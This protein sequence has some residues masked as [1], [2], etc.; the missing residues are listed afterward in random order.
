MAGS[1]T[2]RYVALWVVICGCGGG[3]TL[4]TIPAPVADAAG[5]AMGSAVADA[6]SEQPTLPEAS[7]GAGPFSA[8]TLVA[9][10]SSPGSLDEDPTFTEDLLE[11]YF[12]S[13]RGGN[14]D[15]WRS[16]RLAS[17]DPWGAPMRVAELSS[18]QPDETPSVSLDGLSI[19]I[20][21][22][23][24][25]SKKGNNIW[26]STRLSRASAWGPPTEVTELSSDANDL[27]PA[28][29]EDD[30]LM[31]FASDRPGSA[32]QDMYFSARPD[33]SSPW[34]PPVLIPRVNSNA[35]DWDAFLGDHALQIFFNSDRGG[36]GGDLYFASRTSSSATF[37]AVSPLS[38]LN[39][40][41]NDSDPMLSRD[42]RYIMFGSNRSGNPEIY[43]ARR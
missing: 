8:P 7:L 16:E 35:N 1:A 22:A 40:P 15:I 21:S 19:W 34:S 12:T 4:G 42:L 39:S 33:K 28:T 9:E 5:E 37:G 31:A 11:L 24:P 25:G 6:S 2:F 29:S 23:R 27:A 20:A 36:M 30:L 10:L 43:E 13:D 14:E 18:A 26:V 38:E 32:A 3:E 41:A 17:T